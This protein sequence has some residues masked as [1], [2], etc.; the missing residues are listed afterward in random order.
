[1]NAFCDR[2]PITLSA[3]LIGAA[4]LPMLDKPVVSLLRVVTELYF[5][6]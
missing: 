5:T 6:G 2:F 3:G 1:M 4:T